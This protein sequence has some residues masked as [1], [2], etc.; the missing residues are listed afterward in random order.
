MN[1]M[2]VICILCNAIVYSVQL[3]MNKSTSCNLLWWCLQ[4]IMLLSVS[5]CGNCASTPMDKLC[6]SFAIVCEIYRLKHWKPFCHEEWKM[7]GKHFCHHECKM[8]LRNWMENNSFTM[9]GEIVL[10][11]CINQCVKSSAVVQLC[12]NYLKLYI[13]N[14]Y[15]SSWFLPRNQIVGIG[16]V[17]SC[18]FEIKTKALDFLEIRLWELCVQLANSTLSSTEIDMLKLIDC[19]EEKLYWWFWTLQAALWLLEI[20]I[21]CLHYKMLWYFQRGPCYIW[22]SCWGWYRYQSSSLPSTGI[23]HWC[24]YIQN[25]H[26]TNTRNMNTNEIFSDDHICICSH[27]KFCDIDTLKLVELKLID[28]NIEKSYDKLW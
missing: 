2:Y 18:T 8:N 19:K 14:K 13:W 10:I 27:C 7:N 16:T 25:P 23:N 21:E 24:S 6:F 4:T 17:L 20:L 9:N 1:K 5:V 11:N 22:P 28:W 15:L 26:V 3:C 12:M